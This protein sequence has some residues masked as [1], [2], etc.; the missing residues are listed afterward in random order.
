MNR[1]QALLLILVACVFTFVL[2]SSDDD[3]LQ[4]QEVLQFGRGQINHVAWNPN[5]ETILAVGY[6]QVWL[7]DT[8]LDLI[9]QH[10]IYA[11]IE[12]I[13]WTISVRHPSGSGYVEVER[14]SDNIGVEDVVWSPNGE[15]FAVKITTTEGNA[16]PRWHL[17]RYDENQFSRLL[18][19]MTIHDLQWRADGVF[20]NIFSADAITVYDTQSLEVISTFDGRLASWSPDNQYFAF[21]HDQ[22]V[23][24]ITLPDFAHQATFETG[25]S[26]IKQLEWSNDSTRLAGVSAGRNYVYYGNPRD[27]DESQIFIWDVPSG[28]LVTFQTEEILNNIEVVIKVRRSIEQIA[29]S[30]DDEQL[31]ISENS[32]TITVSTWDTHAGV[33]L[34][35]GG[36]GV[37]RFN[38]MEWITDNNYLL[39]RG[40]STFTGTSVLFAP[41]SLSF[42][43]TYWQLSPDE[44][45]LVAWG[46]GYITTRVFDPNTLA[47]QNEY[48]YER[49]GRINDL[50]WSPDSQHI[51][52]VSSDSK[53]QIA[54][55]ETGQI[56]VS[57]Y[58]HSSS[59]SIIG[60]NDTGDYLMIASQGYAPIRWSQ[61]LSIRV[62]DTNAY[63]PINEFT[64]VFQYA[65]PRARWVEPTSIEITGL[66]EITHLEN[67]SI[68][69]VVTGETLEITSEQ[70]QES[71]PIPSKT[72]ANNTL[73]VEHARNMM[74]VFE[75]GSNE[76]VYSFESDYGYIYDPIWHPSESILFF[77]TRDNENDY[78]TFQVI[79]LREGVPE[80]YV[81]ST[82][83][84][85][86]QIHSIVWHPNG[87]QFITRH[88][89]GTIRLWQE[90]R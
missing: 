87:N 54:D 50:D 45:R 37:L 19:E 46:R 3:T 6:T 57:N 1:Q 35:S 29:W 79:D 16:F 2:S 68:V 85:Y 63:E 27:A 65:I 38:D 70:G 30:L 73:G 25:E 74:N 39:W 26:G 15:W 43:N 82:G 31:A 61:I 5:G 89:D 13:I 80:T 53:M 41:E 22:S 36:L 52:M 14:T 64:E 90:I 75:I 72:N 76:I 51:I 12:S 44:S 62:W 88:G 10:D 24:I 59:P 49:G 67:T 66:H 48:N 17:W 20:F 83:D 9:A 40:S 81:I 21:T 11:E 56:T 78:Y 42:H 33:Q 47:L 8:N 18:P 86:Q 23:E 32:H 69:D 28:D 71:T 77:R 60:W 84:R 7:Y 55:I 58:W 34:S 4:Y